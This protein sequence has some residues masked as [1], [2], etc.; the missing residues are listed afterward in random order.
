MPL[1][2]VGVNQA[3]AE[4]A[5]YNLPGQL[6]A[7]Y[8]WPEPS[9]SSSYFVSK[10]FNTFR[11]PFLW[12][13]AI[14]IV[15]TCPYESIDIFNLMLSL[16][17]R[18]QRNLGEKFEPEYLRR[19]HLAVDE[20][21]LFGANVVLD[22]HN[23]AR[24]SGRI[25]GESHVSISDFAEFWSR[26]AKEFANDDNIIFGLMNEPHSMSTTVWLKA[27]NAAIAAIRAVNAN[28]LILVPGNAWSGAHS[29]MHQRQGGSNAG[30]HC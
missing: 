19:L 24:Y 9:G 23:Y 25:I 15:F 10:G 6:L 18:L 2:Y 22:P 3:G 11:L 28:N 26:L 5:E 8:V 20:M 21:K 7:D 30:G 13:R 27:T 29:W 4:F 16:Q 14:L 12:V 17:E 1:Q